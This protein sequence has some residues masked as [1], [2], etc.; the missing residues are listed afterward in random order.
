MA[1]LFALTHTS[2]TTV[3]AAPSST[4]VTRKTFWSSCPTM[5]CQHFESGRLRFHDRP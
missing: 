1:V 2:D 5:T 4:R 3:A